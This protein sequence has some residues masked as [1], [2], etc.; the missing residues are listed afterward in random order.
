M[1]P[2]IYYILRVKLIR[3]IKNGELDFINDEQEFV[4]ENPIIARERAIR[5]YQNYIDTIVGENIKHSEIVKEISKRISKQEFEIDNKK[6]EFE[7]FVSGI[8]V[9]LKIENPIE[10][11]K[12]G[13]E[14]L[15]H[16]VGFNSSNEQSLMD[17]LNTE[18]SYYKFYKY[19][20]GNYLT[21]IEFYEADIDDTNIETILKTPN[22]W[23]NN[24]INLI[25]FYNK[26]ENQAFAEENQNTNE[27]LIKILKNK[28]NEGEN[29]KVE[30]KASLVSFLNNDDEIGYSKYIRFKIVKTIAS[31]LNSNGGLLFVGIKDDKTILGLHSDFSLSNKVNKEDF[32]RLEVD[33]IIKEYF[34][35]SASLIEGDFIE[36]ENKTIYV[37]QIHPSKKPIFINNNVNKNDEKEF[38]IRLTGASSILINNVDEI[39]G[40]CMNHWCNK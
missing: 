27:D 30:F 26:R 15:I 13:D 40:Y 18:I 33:R 22:D 5:Y 12:K 4:D 20:T 16:G 32:F 2:A 28:I 38:Y 39:I 29:N 24:Q 11:N 21:D 19:K 7:D 8:G 31:F 1:K 23:K 6:F 36:I 9:F 17:N 37:F 10:D 35:S 3:Y 14:F 34:K 25:N